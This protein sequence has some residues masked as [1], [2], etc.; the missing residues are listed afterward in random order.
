MSLAYIHV[1]LV[2]QVPVASKLKRISAPGCD[3][4]AEDLH[5]H[6]ITSLSETAQER[7][8]PHIP[9]KHGVANGAQKNDAGVPPGYS[10]RRRQGIRAT[11]LNSL[12]II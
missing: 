9:Y 1:D 8:R 11:L 4:V 6:G 3:A 2:A 7:E 5:Q 12:Q 10:V